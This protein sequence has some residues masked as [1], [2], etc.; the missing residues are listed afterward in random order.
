M[1]S[2]EQKD[3]NEEDRKQK[4]LDLVVESVEALFDR[5]RRRGQALGLP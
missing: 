2:P 1:P 3:V 5:A 4:A